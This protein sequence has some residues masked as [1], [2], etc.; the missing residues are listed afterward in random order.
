MLYCKNKDKKYLLFDL[1]LFSLIDEAE[2]QVR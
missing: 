2:Q 1:F